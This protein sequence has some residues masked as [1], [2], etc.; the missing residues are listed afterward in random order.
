MHNKSVSINNIFM[1][2]ICLSLYIEIFD[3]NNITLSITKNFIV[4]FYSFMTSVQVQHSH[5]LSQ[6]WY[7]VAA[8][9]YGVTTNVRMF[10]FNDATETFIVDKPYYSFCL[11][12]DVP[13]IMTLSCFDILTLALTNITPI[14]IL[15][16]AMFTV[17][18]AGISCAQW[19]IFSPWGFYNQNRQPILCLVQVRLRTEIPS[20]PSSTQLGFKFMTSTS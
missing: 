11:Q 19:S 3:D 2:F 14:F 10:K 7:F 4:I 12:L 1:C 6:Q 20:T 9:M 18:L 15:F 5:H 17:H 8:Y 13:A 16:K